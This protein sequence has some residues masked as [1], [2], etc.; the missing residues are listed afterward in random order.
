MSEQTLPS[1]ERTP[2]P[3]TR[4]SAANREALVVAA[5]DLFADH[6]PDSISIRTVAAAAGCSHT[7]VG[8]HF[9]SKAGLQQAVIDRLADGLRLLVNLQCSNPQWPTA[10]LIEAFRTHPEAGKLLVRCGLGE[11]ETDALFT[12]HN[13]ARCLAETIEV[14]RCGRAAP[15]SDSTKM[16][17]YGA[18]C[19]VLGLIT[20]EP[21]VV[22]G[23]R[24]D[25]IPRSVRDA[26]IARA[27]DAVAA[28]ALDPDID[29]S[30]SETAPLPEPT[31]PDTTDKR[32]RGRQNVRDALIEASITLFS[33]HNPDGVST[34][35]IAE[36]AG[37][38]QGLIYQYFGSKQVLLT[39]ATEAA[40]AEFG[41]ITIGSGRVDVEGAIR[42]RHLIRS[43]P[44]IAHALVNGLDIG[45]VR[46][47]MPVFDRLL[48][49]YDEIPTGPGTG[50]LD[51]PRLAVLA[52]G[53]FFQGSVIWDPLLRRMLDIPSTADLDEP[54]TLL[55]NHLLDLAPRID[56]WRD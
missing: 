15:L 28:M 34:R 47:K 35:A 3:T 14:R 18:L 1:T 55:M 12:D 56:G 36:L 10:V 48:E 22:R 11:F 21:M 9:G 46:P 32:V 31:V 40:N 2:H 24:A 30:F 26:A 39:E 41:R 25:A 51:D 29:L 54:S 33:R 52:A 6:G 53:L 4:R 13:L 49:D 19:L 42:A 20:F 5:R 45:A 44:I 16:S 8:R 43:T 37:V 50:E 7:L 23:A 27:A 38:N 17:T